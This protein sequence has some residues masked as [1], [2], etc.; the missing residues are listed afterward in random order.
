MA[1]INLGQVIYPVGAIYASAN[2]TSPAS[3]FGGSWTQITNAALRGA[4]WVG[5]SGSDTHALSTKEMPSHSHEI[6]SDPASISGNSERVRIHLSIGRVGKYSEAIR[7]GAAVPTGYTIAKAVG[8][9]QHIP[10]CN[11]LTTV[12]SGNAQAKSS[13]CD[14]A[15]PTSTLDKLCTQ[16]EHTSSP[17][18]QQVLQVYLEELGQLLMR[19][20]SFVPQ[21]VDTMLA[22]KAERVLLFCPQLKCQHILTECLKPLRMAE[23]L[24]VIGYYNGEIN[25]NQMVIYLLIVRAITSH[26]KTDHYIGP[27]TY[28]EEQL[29]LTLGC[30]A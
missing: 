22:H 14:V 13:R 27:H 7:G 17:T 16:L 9:G 3:L 30:D 29:S 8:E 10:T 18:T 12:T 19:D 26:T 11:A 25:L 15:W 1:Y 6:W 2:S 21:V 23:L 24:K 20:D 28:G 4:T 5:Y